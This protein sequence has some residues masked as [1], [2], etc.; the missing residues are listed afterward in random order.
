MN[1]ELSNYFIQSLCI[2]I[3]YY[4]FEHV[5]RKQFLICLKTL[6]LKRRIMVGI[7]DHTIR[8]KRNMIEIVALLLFK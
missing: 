5:L 4:F 3:M 8:M 1:S 7:I 2:I 6:A